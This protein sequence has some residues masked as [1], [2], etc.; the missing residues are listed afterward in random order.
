MITQLPTIDS[1]FDRARAKFRAEFSKGIK[2]VDSRQPI[3]DDLAREMIQQL[4]DY[5]VPKDARIGVVDAFLILSTYLK[6]SGFTN[7]V[8]LENT[9]QNLTESQQKYYNNVKN[10]CEKSGIKYYIP[11]MNNYNR[12]DM[13]FDVIIGNPPYQSDNGGGSCRG[14]TTNP[15]WWEITNVSVKLLKEN[16]I[17]SFVTPT[18]FLNGGDHF[19]T[20]T[21]GNERKYDLKFVDFSADDYFKVGVPICRWV[22]RNSKTKNNQ[23]EVS[24]GRTISADSAFKVT[25]DCILDGILNTLF[26]YDGEKLKFNTSD[27]YDFKPVESYLKK[28]NLPIEW[29]KELKE[30]RDDIYC[31]PVNN[32]G[33][34]K[35]SRIKWKKTGVWRVFYPQL[36]VPTKITVDKE[37]EATAATFTMVFD[38]EEEANLTKSYLESPIYQWIIDKTRVSGR[39]TNII[40]KFP[41]APIESVLSESQIA[42]V[43]SQL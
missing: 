5:E 20:F 30:V 8:L 43:Q 31:Y 37:A 14:S 9:H 29:A 15:L 36:Q 38:T 11:P 16:G 25:K 22:L 28:Q 1:V 21:L 32:N 18:N 19:T 35:Y 7:L 23:I 42:Y 4:V 2:P 6:E 10:L 40:S 24:D 12:C 34:I 39:V 26:S 3:P 13:K 33:K 17:L 27:R 41:N